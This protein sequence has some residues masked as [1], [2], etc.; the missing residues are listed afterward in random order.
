MGD[1]ATY[2]ARVIVMVLVGVAIGMVLSR[3]GTWGPPLLFLAICTC[4]VG[5]AFSG[6]WAGR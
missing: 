1:W 3:M 2:V 6:W 5:A 4:G